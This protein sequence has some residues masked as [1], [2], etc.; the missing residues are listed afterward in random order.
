MQTDSTSRTSGII[1]KIKKFAFPD[2]YITYM[3]I[4]FLSTSD[5]MKFVIPGINVKTTGKAIH[6]LAKIGDEIYLEPS[7]D[8]LTL[9]S[10]NLSRSGCRMKITFY[11]YFHCRSAFA[12]FCFGSSF[13]SS[14]EQ[15]NPGTENCKVK[16]F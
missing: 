2:Y 3:I 1:V 16:V 14:I 6:C 9:R 13:F 4:M 7:L 10:V 8:S 12:Q 11:L 5:K 15:D